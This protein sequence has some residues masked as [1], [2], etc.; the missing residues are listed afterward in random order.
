[1]PVQQVVKVDFIVSQEPP[2]RSA[3][4]IDTP[5]QAAYPCQGSHRIERSFA[6]PAH[7]RYCAGFQLPATMDSPRALTTGG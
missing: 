7:S 3:L 4:G 2:R 6:A 1:M 5:K